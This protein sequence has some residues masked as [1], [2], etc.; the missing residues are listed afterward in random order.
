MGVQGVREGAEHAPLCGPSVDGQRS[1]LPSPPGAARQKV[2]DTIVQ[3]GVE[4][5][6]LQLDDELGRYYGVEC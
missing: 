5:R 6:G 1:F 3:G 4:T 2:K